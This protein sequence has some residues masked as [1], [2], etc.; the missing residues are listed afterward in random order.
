[1]AFEK[2]YYEASEATRRL[3]AGRERASKTLG[4]FMGTVYKIVSKIPKGK[5]ATY[6][7]VAEAAGVPGGARAV[8]NAMANNDDTKRVPCH[9]VVQSTG[10]V[11]GYM[12]ERHQK[13]NVKARKL[14]AEGIE[15]NR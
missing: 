10:Y 5:V 9:R 1:M 8:G 13:S 11:G 2:F 3:R 14:M 12:G 7:D 15:I 6:G 4:S